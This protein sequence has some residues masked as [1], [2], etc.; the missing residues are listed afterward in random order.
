MNTLALRA[1]A[2][3]GGAA[4]F[5]VAVAGNPATATGL[6]RLFHPNVTCSTPT[7]CVSG[8]N[9]GSGEGVF[10]SATSTDGISASASK[11]GGIG[12]QA[13]D[14]SGSANNFGIYGKSPHGT[15]VVGT[16]S[17]GVGLVALSSA[18]I[19]L[20]AQTG[21]SGSAL[22]VKRTSTY[23][24]ALVGGLNAKGD[25]LDVGQKNG[26]MSLR[27][28]SGGTGYVTGFVFTQGTCHTGCARTRDGDE[29]RVTSYAPRESE[30]TISFDGE[31][32]LVRGAARVVLDPSIGD[33]A[34]KKAG[35]AVFLTPE[36]SSQGLHVSAKSPHGFSV[37][38]N[39]GGRS[40]LAF[41]YRVVAKAS[42]APL[43]R[44]PVVSIAPLPHLRTPQ[45][46]VAR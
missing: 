19:G 45:G 30:P 37:V 10:G 1:A 21:T 11:F 29:V 35:Y 38:E 6:Q 27:V 26:T 3:L 5:G 32:Q 22:A 46:A 24:T 8:D 40:T 41:A 20:F 25:V 23:E 28:T 42:G 13:V 39:A 36:G 33:N 2:L 9:S 43:S 12:A 17:S 31:A 14:S 34:D 44:L 18:G 7:P 15:G 4:V 16:S